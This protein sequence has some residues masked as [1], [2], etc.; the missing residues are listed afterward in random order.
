MLLYHGALRNTAAQLDRKQPTCKKAWKTNN[1][2]AVI[3]AQI[4]TELKLLHLLS[5]VLCLTSCY[6]LWRVYS[7]STCPLC[8]IFQ[9]SEPG[10]G[11][12]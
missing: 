2:Q 3:S 4:G 12:D 8:T 6:E 1:K 11:L 10:C 9:H 5:C 7:L